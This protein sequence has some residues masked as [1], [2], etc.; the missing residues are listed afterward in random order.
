MSLKVFQSHAKSS[1]F[2]SCTG[3][4]CKNVITLGPAS[5]H[6]II[7]KPMLEANGAIL[8]TRYFLKRI[9]VKYTDYDGK[10]TLQT[11][12]GQFYYKFK[13]FCQIAN[14]VMASS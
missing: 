11:Y 13:I 6:S 14:L 3:L 5:S 2:G 12:H 1:H 4:S 7:K 9:H 8:D 10:K